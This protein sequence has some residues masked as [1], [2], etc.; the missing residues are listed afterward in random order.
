MPHK[1]FV[2]SKGRV[3][4]SHSSHADFSFQLAAPIEVGQ[5]RAFIDQVH[6]PNEFPTIHE[7]NRYIYIEES[8]GGTSHKRKLALSEGV[9]DSTTLPAHLQ[10][11]LNT[12]TSMAANSYTV[13]FSAV[14]G[15]LT[16]STSDATNTFYVWTAEA[17][18]NG[19][20]NPLASGS[21]PVYT[22]H[23][24][25][26]DVLGFHNP[27]PI[28]GAASAGAEGTAHINIVP[29]HTLYIHSDLGTQADCVDVMGGSSVIRTVC[30][31][32]PTGRYVHDRNTSAFDYISISKG[33]IRQ[34]DFRL[35]DWRGRVVPLTNSWSFSIIIVP[36]EDM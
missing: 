12:G 29:F 15:K 31:D 35:T 11:I 4:P 18:A 13:A 9:Y 32:Q 26:Y 16:I 17:L 14:S 23:D 24:D 27:I 30:L 21:I 22:A 6:L 33:M 19:L 28:P 3:N 20:W 5:S 8:V 25:A 10:T 36:E 2:H 7:A 34:M 1:V